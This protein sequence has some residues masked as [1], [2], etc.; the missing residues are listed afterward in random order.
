MSEVSCAIVAA[1]DTIYNFCSAVI[2][3]ACMVCRAG[4][5]PGGVGVHE[6]VIT[7]TLHVDSKE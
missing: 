2:E 3:E 1:A 4:G 7:G 5:M 6:L